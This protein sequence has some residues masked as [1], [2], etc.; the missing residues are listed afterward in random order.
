MGTA[1][2]GGLILAWVALIASLLMGSGQRGA[3]SNIAALI[4]ILGG[5]V[6]I[7]IVAVPLEVLKGLINV[8]RIEERHIVSERFFST[9]ALDVCQQS[10]S[11]AR[12]SF[13]SLRWL[14]TY[15]DIIAIL[16]AFVVML[17][18]ISILG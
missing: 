16:V 3:F 18:S 4:L 6:G 8:T 11:S 13:G 7:T 14:L 5:S 2:V 15:A 9:P 12:R 10:K 17:Y 1:K